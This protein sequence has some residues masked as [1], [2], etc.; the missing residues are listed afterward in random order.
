MSDGN[1]AGESDRHI[2]D[3][4]I[5]QANDIP[6]LH[7]L[8]TTSPSGSSAPHAIC[9]VAG[10]GMYPRSV[11]VCPPV[12]VNLGQPRM[13]LEVCHFVLDATAS[14][15]L[16]LWGR[17]TCSILPNATRTDRLRR[18]LRLEARHLL[19]IHAHARCE[20]VVHPAE[21]AVKRAVHG[22][23]SGGASVAA[24]LRASAIK[25]AKIGGGGVYYCGGPNKEQAGAVPTYTAR[26]I[27]RHDGGYALSR[28]ASVILRVIGEGS[29][30]AVFHG[31]TDSMNTR[32]LD[33]EIDEALIN[34]VSGSSQDWRGNA[35]HCIADG[36][37][38]QARHHEEEVGKKRKASPV[39]ARRAKP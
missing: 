33:L 27:V 39:F 14:N 23:A 21:Y 18:R 15:E 9:R 6:N 12:N 17:L 30:E 34:I 29:E 5:R 1:E 10:G 36:L 25:P 13:C 35:L 7:K 28:T 26:C 3:G 24:V 8:M 19:R 4:P 38:E 32:Y 22:D 37:R 2:R 31:K 16:M 11:F 20:P